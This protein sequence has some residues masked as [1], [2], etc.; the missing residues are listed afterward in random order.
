LTSTPEDVE[1]LT[2][3]G[4]ICVQRAELTTMSVQ[5]SGAP[6]GSQETW[7]AVRALYERGLQAYAAACAHADARVGDD[8]AGL[9][10]NWGAGLLSLAEVKP[11]FLELAIV[12]YL[13]SFFCSHL[14]F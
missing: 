5:Q 7:A 2:N 9:L 10:Q 8:V 11:I 14:T 1:L 3:V 4:D 13:Q 12:L 6:S